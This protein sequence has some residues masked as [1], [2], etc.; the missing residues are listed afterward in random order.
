MLGRERRASVIF[1]NV[2]VV[3]AYPNKHIMLNEG[4]LVIRITIENR[5]DLE[6]EPVTFY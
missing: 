6:T 3:Q 1:I 4:F 2:T 5:A